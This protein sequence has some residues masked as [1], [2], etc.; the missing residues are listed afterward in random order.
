M[1][2]IIWIISRDL[3]LKLFHFPG[4]GE[5]GGEDNKKRSDLNNLFSFCGG[6]KQQ[7]KTKRRN[8]HLSGGYEFW[9]ADAGHCGY[10]GQVFYF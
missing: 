6:V 2:K 1:E 10:S 4:G 7:K 3:L 9:P 8:S 5:R